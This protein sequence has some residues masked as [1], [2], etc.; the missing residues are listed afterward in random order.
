MREG[1][2]SV[3]F[4]TG[5]LAETA[6]NMTLYKSLDPLENEKL[7]NVIRTALLDL[8]TFRKVK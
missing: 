6:D 2:S 1:E 8:P 7:V 3:G 5:I 4:P